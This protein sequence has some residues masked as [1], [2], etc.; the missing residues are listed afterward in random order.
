M[1]PGVQERGEKLGISWD[2][3][4]HQDNSLHVQALDASQLWEPLGK[5]HSS[6][7]P[8]LQRMTQPDSGFKIS[9][10]PPD[11]GSMPLPFSF[12]FPFFG[13]NLVKGDAVA[14]LILII[15]LWPNSDLTTDIC[16]AFRL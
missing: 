9:Q 13:Q 8:G 11:P 10:L 14:A 16:P 4:L 2:W 3:A 5:M 15:S 12:I 7:P 6:I 1:R